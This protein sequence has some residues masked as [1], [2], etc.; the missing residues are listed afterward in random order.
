[1]PNPNVHDHLEQ[2]RSR[3]IAL[4]VP[5]C[6]TVRHLTGIPDACVQ[7]PFVDRDAA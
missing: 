4:R 5:P 2:D 3:S 1:M 6:N 7:W